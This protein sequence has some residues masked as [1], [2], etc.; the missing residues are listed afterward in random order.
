MLEA[1][2]RLSGIAAE[3]PLPR[4]A[5][6]APGSFAFAT[7][8][9]RAAGGLASEWARLAA[10]SAGDNV[11]FHPDFAIPAMR[12]LGRDAVSVANVTVAGKLV[13]IAPFVRARLGRIARAVRLWS[14]PYGPL[15]L[16]LIAPDKVDE[17]VA[18]LAEGLVPH[19]AGI[20]LIVPDLPLD[21][22]V[23]C[24]LLRFAEMA[25]RPTVVLDAH[26]RAV[27]D[28]PPTGA[29]DLR[30]GLAA[31]RRKEY[32]RQMRRLGALGC[33]TVEAAVE[34]DHVRCRFAEFMT[35][36][37]GGWKGRGGTALAS[38]PAIAEF[39]RAAIS[40]RAD[41]G[42]ARIHSIRL[43][44]RP[45]AVLVSLLAGATAFTWKIAYDE[46]YA[47]FSP[48]A[49]L[50][51]EAAESLLSDRSIVRI[52]SCATADHPMVNRLWPGRMAIGTLVIGPPG[53]GVAY[54]L[55]VA[56]ARGEVAARARVRRLREHL[57]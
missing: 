47:R 50:M 38:L 32:A 5:E 16:P 23:A 14:H 34:P 30:S 48:G 2:A 18:A 40:N 7:V 41:A 26:A 36:E 13:A 43:D 29:L 51:M 15:G 3:R 52:N 56:A 53:A 33:V 27:L 39:A 49:Q 31:R 10:R 20:S 22:P 9:S 45:I 1:G 17:A 21:G 25:D 8:S 57:S 4:V 37:A 35:V 12:H 11:F 46:T 19:G 24:A 42:A 6:H 44:D 54:R 28:R 55:G